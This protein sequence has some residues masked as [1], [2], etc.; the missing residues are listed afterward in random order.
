MQQ[1]ELPLQELIRIADA[2]G[3]SL[4]VL[5]GTLR[6]VYGN[7]VI[8]ADMRLADMLHLS[9]ELPIRGFFEGSV[10][11]EDRFYCVRIY[12]LSNYTEPKYY[13][14]EVLDRG[15]LMSMLSRTSESRRVTG[16]LGSLEYRVKQAAQLADALCADKT[17]DTKRLAAELCVRIGRLSSDITELAEYNDSLNAPA[18]RVLFD[19]GALCERLCVRCNEALAKSG[20]S[21]ALPL[22]DDGLYV[23][24]DSRR[25]VI[26]LLSAIEYSVLH[27][28]SDG[29]AQIVAYRDR[30]AGQVVIKLMD[31]PDAMLPLEDGDFTP[32]LAAVC[33]CAKLAGGSAGLSS[34]GRTALLLSLPAAAPEELSL[35]RL[36]E[37][38]HAM[39]DDIVASRLEALAKQCEMTANVQ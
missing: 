18:E 33:R 12:A 19:A 29:L 39:Y 13:L 5:D 17:A 15:V 8:K 24:A 36:E 9:A 27:S 23:C 28:H 20:K 32:E 16:M 6:C 38:I 30:Q 25:A 21:I 35:Y 31:I 37:D 2:S 34:G 26:M 22:C 3:L 1:R 4:C 11:V 7:A 10:T 14:C